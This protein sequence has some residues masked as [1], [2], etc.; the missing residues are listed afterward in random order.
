MS[1]PVSWTSQ[2]EESLRFTPEELEVSRRYIWDPV[3]KAILL[4]FIAAEPGYTVLDVGSGTGFLIRE[5]AADTKSGRFIGLDIDPDLVAA[6]R[7]LS[8]N[9]PIEYI[10]GSVYSL[11][12]ADSSVDIVTAEFVMCNL[13][14]PEAAIAECV[15]VL[16]P[17]GHLVCIDPPTSRRFLYSPNIPEWVQE[18][19]HKINDYVAADCATRGID[20]AIGIRLPELYMKAGLDSIEVRGHLNTKLECQ[21]GSPAEAAA[22]A[23]HQLSMLRRQG[24]RLQSVVRGGTLTQDEA[25]R[26]TAF[27]TDRRTQAL[28]NPESVFSDPTCHISTALIVKGHKRRG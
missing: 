4:D 21:V 11:P 13:T 17:G 25:D 9:Q 14:R 10:E 20:K 26:Y 27:W 19:E 5:I 23:R 3:T 15:R 22:R 16:R 6:A 24:R 8:A 7:Q 28:E 18:V 1:M 12:F 2:D